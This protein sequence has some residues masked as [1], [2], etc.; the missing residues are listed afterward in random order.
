M[1]QIRKIPKDFTSIGT[2]S[3]CGG[4]STGF[5]MAGFDVLLANEF[6]D[7]ARETYELNHADTERS[8]RRKI[9]WDLT[10]L[11]HCHHIGFQLPILSNLIT[12]HWWPDPFC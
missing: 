3:G 9:F 12:T 5:K 11:F 7:I 1:K 2:F 10:Y 6:V 8:D 4:S